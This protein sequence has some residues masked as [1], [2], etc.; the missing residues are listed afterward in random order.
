[1]PDTPKPAPAATPPPPPTPAEQMALIEKYADEGDAQAQA[2]WDDLLQIR[3]DLWGVQSRIDRMMERKTKTSA[4]FGS[5]RH[6]A[7]TLRT[8]TLTAVVTAT[9][10]VL[11]AFAA[12][13]AAWWL[14]GSGEAAATPDTPVGWMARADQAMRG[15]D[16]RAAAAAYRAA[17]ER[18]GDG[19]HCL[20]GLA[21]CRMKLG[22][23][24]AALAVAEELVRL[25][26]DFARGHTLKGLVYL[27]AG[28]RA[29]AL[30]EFRRAARMGDTVA[31]THLPAGGPRGDGG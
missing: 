13:P 8:P 4:A 11:V 21:E 30:D 24:G 14:A 23:D 17:Y 10:V 15:R 29:D 3:A 28:R 26:P 9:A 19:P 1:M 12:A 18:G 5:I 6:A 27:R 31:L 22:E 16:Y 7:R 2:N 20:G 25:H